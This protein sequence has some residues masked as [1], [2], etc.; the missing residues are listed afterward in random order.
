MTPE[1]MQQIIDS[2]IPI[3]SE[4]GLNIVGAIAILIIGWMVAGWVK[5][6]VNKGLSRIE[7]MD[8]TLKPFISSAARYVIL[9]FVIV[10]VLN[11]FGVETTSIIAVLGAAGLA[12]GLA[13]QGT[14]SNVAAGVMLLLLRPF[15]TGEYVD[16][17][18]VSGTV[19]EIGLFSTEFTT[20]QGV[21]ILA[22]NASL[23]GSAITNYSRNTTRRADVS[24]G[25][26]YGDDIEAARKALMDL[27]TGDER[28]NKD[29]APVVLVTLLG[30][31]SVNLQMRCWADTDVFWPVYFD[32]TEDCKA[33]VEN[34]GCSIPFP[35]RDVHMIPVKD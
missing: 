2:I 1:D 31:S 12:I 24:V 34:A 4:Y 27:M 30:D 23:W 3:V 9:V 29:P 26:A 11:Q 5:R 17:G 14:L 21:C 20:P 6:A 18:S 32:L 22:P 16:A 35:Q 7:R 28:I 33:A 8:A 15:R 25:I 13:L 19:K 10:G